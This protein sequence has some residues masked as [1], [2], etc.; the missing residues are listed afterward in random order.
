LAQA[1][2][3]GVELMAVSG[4]RS[5]YQAQVYINEVEQDRG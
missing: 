2:A 3:T 1:G 5:L 4:H